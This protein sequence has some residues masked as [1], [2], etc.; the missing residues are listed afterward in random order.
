VAAA[1]IVVAMLVTAVTEAVVAR[2]KVR[3][4]PGIGAR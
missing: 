4:R 2:A 1:R 3:S